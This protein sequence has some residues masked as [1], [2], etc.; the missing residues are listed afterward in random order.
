LNLYNITDVSA[1]LPAPFATVSGDLDE[2]AFDTLALGDRRRTG[3]D[4]FRFSTTYNDLIPENHP[5]AFTVDPINET[6]AAED[7]VYSSTLADDATDPENNIL[8]FSKVDGPAWMSVSTNGV[9]SG[10]PGA[11]DVGANVFTVKVE[12]AELASDTATL[13]ITVHA[14]VEIP[15]NPEELH[16]YL[17]IGQSNMAGRAP[18]MAEESGIIQGCFL[19]NDLDSWEPAQLPLNKYST[20]RKS[21]DLQKLNPG[22]TFSKTLIASNSAVSVGL[23]VNAR[24]GS[25]ITEW[26][27]SDT[28]YTEAIRRTQIARTNGTLK[29]VLWHQG[30]SD[31]TDAQYIQKLT[32]LVANLRSDLGEPNLPFVAGEIKSDGTLINGQINQLPEL[33]PFTGVASSAGLTLQDKWHFDAPSQKLLGQRYAEEML[34][35][36]AAQSILPAFSG[37]QING[38]SVT[39]GLT[40][41]MPNV[42]INILE[43]PSL[44]PPNWSTTATFTAGTVAT[45]WAVSTTDSTMFYIMNRE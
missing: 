37:I 31:Y 2:T 36:H 13:N 19:L 4:E 6:D 35:I 3:F 40:N 24:G 42:V 18:Y 45:N 26:E 25:S 32:N 38:N 41:L 15:S 21:L 33:V 20:I 7:E 9:L 12:D 44:T 16:I 14:A 29:G 28:Y 17:L 43:S 30:E 34:K 11:G 1:P 10:T 8:T 39:M 5:P 27:R 22:Y 23:V